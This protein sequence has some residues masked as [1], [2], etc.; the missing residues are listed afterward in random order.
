MAEKQVEKQ[1]EQQ[2]EK[3]SIQVIERMMSLLEVLADT[4][5]PASLKLLAQSTGLHPS[6]AHR[7]L[8]A[9]TF[10][11]LVERQETGTYAL[12][13][14]LLELGNIVKSRINI[15]EIAL[16]FMQSLHEA[17]G[18]AINLGI[19]HEDEIIYAERTSSGR[20]LVRVVYLV[21]G[22]APLHLTSVGKLFLAADSV[23]DVRAYAKRTGLPGKTPHSLTNLGALEKEL[24]KIRRHDLSYDN[25]EA[26]L[27]LRCVA[28]PIRNDEGMIVA[29]LSIS[30]PTDRHNPE[31]VAQIKSTADAISHA[32][33]YCKPRS[34]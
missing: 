26:E 32:L 12:G 27:G 23:A 15:R 14:R 31:W 22:R 3:G 34:K 24:D 4:P 25:E 16:P 9:M 5:E 19:R 28:A 29:G 2:A 18:E 1:A 6:T 33:G 30:A 21:G 20:S 11:H 17:I 10:S 8:A 13:I 7:I